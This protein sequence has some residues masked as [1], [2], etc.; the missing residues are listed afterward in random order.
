MC[1]DAFFNAFQCLTNTFQQVFDACPRLFYTC[2][3][4]SNTFEYSFN[5]FSIRLDLFIF[6]ILFNTFFIIV[7]CFCMF[8]N[9]CEHF[10]ILFPRLSIVFNTNKYVSLFFQYLAMLSKTF[11]DTFVILF[12]YFCQYCLIPFQ[13]FF[14]SLPCF[15]I[16]LSTFQH[17]FVIFYTLKYVCN[18]FKYVGLSGDR[19]SRMRVF[20]DRAFRSRGASMAAPWQRLLVFCFFVLC[21]LHI[22]TKLFNARCSRPHL[23][24]GWCTI[25]TNTTWRYYTDFKTITHPLSVPLFLRHSAIA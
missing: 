15:V 4:L 17:F 20:C 5:V 1:F 10:S 18:T 24:V 8:F 23:N 19:C 6:S 16:H 22:K 12:N 11:C 3:I 7:L 13:Y 14:Y 25:H 2:S 9:T 21:K